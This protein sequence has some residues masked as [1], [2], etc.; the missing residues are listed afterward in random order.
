MNLNVRLLGEHKVVHRYGVMLIDA[1]EYFVYKLL[2]R[3]RKS[4]IVD[5]KIVDGDRMPGLKGDIDVTDD[6]WFTIRINNDLNIRGKL[7]T[8]AHECV[9]LKQYIRGEMIDVDYNSTLWKG[10]SIANNLSS[11]QT[12]YEIEATG[13]GTL[14]FERFLSDKKLTNKEEYLDPDYNT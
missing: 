9:H 4:I 7:L 1:C 6:D 2:P 5:I 13:I 11:Y 3:R 14:I 8:L 10:K 12:E